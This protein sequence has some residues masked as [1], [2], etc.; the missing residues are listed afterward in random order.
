[1]IPHDYTKKNGPKISFTLLT[2]HKIIWIFISRQKKNN[3]PMFYHHVN[4]ISIG[5]G[6]L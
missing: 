3:F 1:M 6:Y 5:E 4:N 2:Q